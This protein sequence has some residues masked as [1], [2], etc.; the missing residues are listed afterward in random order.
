MCRHCGGT[1]S[2]KAVRADQAAA[3][4]RPRDRL[5]AEFS[6]SAPVRRL[7]SGAVRRLGEIMRPIFTLHAGEYLVADH[8]EKTYKDFRVWVPSKDTGVDLLVTDKDHRNAVSLQVKFSK[9]FMNLGFKASGW[10]TLKPEKIAGSEADLWVFAL[11]NFD[12]R[13]PHYIIIPPQ[14]LG[15]MLLTL[16]GR[17]RLFQT[18]FCVSN[19]NRCWATRGLSKADELLIAQGTYENPAR[20]FTPYLENWEPL[21]ERLRQKR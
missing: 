10:W 6:A 19:I 15:E 18:Y 12:K 8:L 3:A 21:E 13:T 17:E 7:L 4:D 9:D 14:R 2:K 11:Y 5:L 20:D 1:V 16:H